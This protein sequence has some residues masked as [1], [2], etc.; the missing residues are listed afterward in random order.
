[1]L[2]AFAGVAGMQ[3]FIAGKKAEAAA[4]MPE[5]VSEIT[6]MQVQPREWTP[7]FSAVGYIRPNQ[8][9]MLSAESSGTVKSVNVKSGQRVNKGDLLVEFDDA[10][11]VATLKASQAHYQMP[12][13]P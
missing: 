3:R 4:N 9:A 10:V 5:T 13:L 12:K 2:V 7:Y 8:G 11:E 1:M 6:A